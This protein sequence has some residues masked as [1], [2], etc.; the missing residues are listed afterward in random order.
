MRG[1]AERGIDR[2]YSAGDGLGFAIHESDTGDDLSEP[3]SSGDLSPG[4]GGILHQGV[5]HGGLRHGGQRGQP[6]D[7]I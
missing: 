6:A 2:D 3:L 5:H 1:R 4:L 7:V